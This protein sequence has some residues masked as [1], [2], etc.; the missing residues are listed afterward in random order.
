[1]GYNP[2]K[3]KCEMV[4]QDGE[5][6]LLTNQYYLADLVTGKLVNGTGLQGK[7]FK[8]VRKENENDNDSK[9]NPQ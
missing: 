5:T 4:S 1:M 6:W 8:L 9:T 2:H 7:Q 3:V